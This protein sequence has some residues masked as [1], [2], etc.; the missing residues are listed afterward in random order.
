MLRGADGAAGG[1][2]VIFQDVTSV[3]QMERELRRLERLAGVG[4]LAASIAHEIRNPLA[5]ISGSVEML[6]RN[7][8]ARAATSRG[9]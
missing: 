4:Q 9:G 7:A 2:V 3:V 1:Y 8:G 5:A 6:L